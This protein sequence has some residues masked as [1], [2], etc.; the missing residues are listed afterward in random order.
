MTKYRP[1]EEMS[2]DVLNESILETFNK[3]A[4]NRKAAL[5][6]AIFT[7]MNIAALPITSKTPLVFPSLGVAVVCAVK[8]GKILA[9]NKSLRKT[10]RS[11]KKEKKV[12]K[13]EL[14]NTL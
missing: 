4:E 12:R 6:Y 14:Q 13:S 11:L 2:N 3:I 8:T 7:A 10:L 1:H 5:P 9:G